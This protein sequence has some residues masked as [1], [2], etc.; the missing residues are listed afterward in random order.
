MKKTFI[1]FIL[2]TL[3]VSALCAQ[4]DLDS[5]VV[6][7]IWAGGARSTLEDKVTFSCRPS[8]D[9]FPGGNILLSA[10]VT[11]DVDAI[12]FGLSYQASAGFVFAGDSD[13]E[14]VFGAFFGETGTNT[15]TYSQISGS[16]DYTKLNIL[17]VGIMGRQLWGDD[18]WSSSETSS[19]ELFATAGYRFLAV[20][21][22]VF[23][24]FQSVSFAIKGVAGFYT[25][26]V[27]GA[28]ADFEPAFG[29]LVE[30]R[31][32]LVATELGY[33]GDSFYWSVYARIPLCFFL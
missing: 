11:L 2:L 9:F 5:F 3:A 29:G 27:N 13:S 23:P 15:T 16:A 26:S 19:H 18:Y 17:E 28:S 32:Y 10:A 21:D 8:V 22:T 20:H 4:N 6:A 1:L 12:Y 25:I 14:E 33:I 7:D 24:V 30:F 31:Y